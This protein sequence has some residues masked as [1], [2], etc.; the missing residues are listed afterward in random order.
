MRKKDPGLHELSKLV[1]HVIRSKT[2]QWRN[3]EAHSPTNQTQKD[4][5]WKKSITQKIMIKRMRVKIKIKNRL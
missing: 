1:T 3:Y 5:T 2:Q 4:K